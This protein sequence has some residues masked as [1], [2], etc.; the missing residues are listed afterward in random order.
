VT[1]AVDEHQDQADAPGLSPRQKH[2][3][4]WVAAVR[5]A[6]RCLRE[7]IADELAAGIPALE[8]A[9]AKAAA[10]LEDAYAAV[11]G[12]QRALADLDDEISRAE[13][14]L[15]SWTSQLEDGTVAERVTARQWISE[16]E[17]ELAVLRQKREFAGTQL[18]PFTAAWDKA[19][20]GLERATEELAG[21]KLNATA[22]F[23]YYGAGQETDAYS[24]RFGR[25]LEVALRD[26]G[27]YEHRAAVEHMLFL[28]A[29]S[30]FRTEAYADRLPSDSE[31]A[32]RFWDS[33]YENASPASTVPTGQEVIRSMHA[34]FEVS[35]EN[36]RH[37]A[38]PAKVD[39]YRYG[40]PRDV[41]ERPY[42]DVPKL[43][44]FGR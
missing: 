14:E 23:A 16:W 11:E 4:A 27:H 44:D 19:R 18:Q 7:V 31:Q 6:D 24:L 26:R 39:D 13:A 10:A 40:P 33:V 43:S 35:A 34:E 9:Q 12:P 20:T 30:G 22:A 36:K 21:R 3:A 8:Q 38:S 37:E 42:M 17:A 5:A 2:L 25:D 32:R 15:A 28:C 41:P 1:A 29:S